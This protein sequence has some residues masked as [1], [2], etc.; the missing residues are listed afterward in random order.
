[1]N[2]TESTST[3][4][5]L[6]L[7]S[8]AASSSATWATKISLKLL[9][10]LLSAS[11]AAIPMSDAEE[12]CRSVFRTIE[13]RSATCKSETTMPDVGQV[14]RDAYGYNEEELQGRCLPFLRAV[15]CD[16]GMT[17]A[18]FYAHCGKAIYL[19]TW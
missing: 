16:V 15:P 2:P 6:K 14:C 17:N 4:S 7:A 8:T 18:D 1:M 9:T 11:C 12:A 13:D 19:K 5:A 3:R 10:I